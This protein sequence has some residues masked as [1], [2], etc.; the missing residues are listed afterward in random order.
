MVSSLA[1]TRIAISTRNLRLP[2]FRLYESDR[3]YQ[4]DHAVRAVMQLL[5]PLDFFFI[6]TVV[7]EL[8]LST[9][10]RASLACGAHGG[11]NGAS[12]PLS[13]KLTLSL[14]Y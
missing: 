13:R 2:S 4:L 5:G 7:F 1:I 3:I 11:V 12:W 6:V 14:C 9:L 8:T 10:Q